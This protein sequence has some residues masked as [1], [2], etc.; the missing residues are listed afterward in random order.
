LK[1]RGQNCTIEKL[2]GAKVPKS[3]T[4]HVNHATTRDLKQFVSLTVIKIFTYLIYLLN[5]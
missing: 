5:I 4:M 2:G 1:L 3:K